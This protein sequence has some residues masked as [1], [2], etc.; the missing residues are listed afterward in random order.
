LV[1]AL[2]ASLVLG[3]RS[4]PFLK[5]SVYQEVILW[6]AVFAFSFLVLALK[7]LTAP[8]GFSPRR[9]LLMAILA[10]CC[11]LTRVVMATGLFAGVL[12]L[13]AWR[14]VGEMSPGF[15][16][17]SE[18]IRASVRQGFRLLTS[19]FIAPLIVLILFG[20]AA[21]LINYKRFGNPLEFGNF[22][23]QT[24][25]PTSHGV[26]VEGVPAL[27]KYGAFNPSRLPYGLMYYFAPVWFVHTDDGDLLFVTDPLLL[28]LAVA[29]LGAVWRR[30]RMAV[31]RS[32]AAAIAATLA[33]PPVLMLMAFTMAFRYRMEF[34]PL[35]VFLALIGAFGTKPEIAA[36]RPRSAG[37]LIVL[38][39]VG[40]I[41][42][43]LV[44]GAYKLSF[45]GNL[46]ADQD[47][48][49]IY[50]NEIR[51]FLVRRL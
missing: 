31:S 33:V 26:H 39:I 21:G 34:Y 19:R 8:D 37:G 36:P 43:H 47:L 5:A 38:T 9:L 24:H 7:G 40:I 1:W 11:L 49:Q 46:R 32:A 13:L 15:G 50:Q 18:P 42:S 29:G 2:F 4:V 12:A 35:F 17:G 45:W 44:L 48:W 27:E 14:F 6:E 10:G 30:N 28:M 22:S 23:I 3:G 51:S 16:D 25:L 41:A 20:L